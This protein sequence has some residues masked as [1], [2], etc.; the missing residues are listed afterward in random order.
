M[1]AALLILGL[2][3]A[4][5]LWPLVSERRRLPMDAEARTEAEGEFAALSQGITHYEWIGPLRGPVAVCVHGLTTPSFVWRGFARGLAAWGYRVLIYDLYGRGYSDRPSG[6]QD[7]EF[8][9]TQL[10]DLLAHQG[11]EDDFTLV[12]YSMGG[13]IA[14][15]YAARHPD[16]VRRLI[17]LA[18]AGMGLT[19]TR[20]I[21][22]IRD[23]RILGDWLMLLLFPLQHRRSTN[24]ERDLPSSVPTIVDR[25]QD[26]L[27]YRGYV[28]AVL[29]SLRGILSEDFEPDHRRLRETDVPVIA[30]W[31]DKDS[32]VP[33]T[34]MGKLTQWSRHARQEVVKGA[35]HGLPYTHTDE[36]L[37]ALRSTLTDD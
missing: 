4:I 26:E 34:A 1:I 10:D 17:L 35:G 19:A 30:L 11:I 23:K 33:L 6:P 22:T 29:S 20:L 7:R 5:L 28:P 16:T 31:G 24:A 3:L 14:T 25:Q 13:A 37:A 8:F 2:I 21:Q 9:L 15:A 12:G 27:M 18:P 32:V 36:V